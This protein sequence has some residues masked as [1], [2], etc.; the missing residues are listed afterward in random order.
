M[1]T[2]KAEPQGQD[3]CAALAQSLLL[4]ARRWRARLNERL[5]SIGQTDARCAALAEIADCED[6]VVQREL[7]QRLGVEEPTVVRLLDALEAG[8]WV[9]RRAHAVD[10]RAKVVQVT[11]AAQPVLDDAQAIIFE[12][13]QEMFSEIDPSDLAV[14]L[15]VLNELAR[16]LERV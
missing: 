6:G 7:S 15:R 12:L 16:K 10:R 3:V 9:Q 11:P 1:Y 14:C 13:Q 5:K 4:A 8:G 2:A